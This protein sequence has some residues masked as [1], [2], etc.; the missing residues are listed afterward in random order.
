MIL[1]LSRL[2]E[3]LYKLADDQNTDAHGF[4]GRIKREGPGVRTFKSKKIEGPRAYAPRLSK[5]AISP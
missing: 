2:V 3:A 5:P 1:K 4:E